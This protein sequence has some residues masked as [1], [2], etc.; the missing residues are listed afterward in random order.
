MLRVMEN[1]GTCPYMLQE[2][3]NKLFDKPQHLKRHKEAY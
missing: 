2:T 3:R 1:K